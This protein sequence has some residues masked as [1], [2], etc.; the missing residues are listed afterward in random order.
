MR[1]SIIIPVYNVEKYL[2]EC[3]DSILSQTIKDFEIILVDDGST[4]SSGKICD[5]YFVKYSNIKVIH[6]NNGGLSEARNIGLRNA[7]GEY[8][9]FV[10]SDDY[11]IDNNVINKLNEKLLS[12]PDIVIFTHIKWFESSGKMSIPNLNLI[13]SRNA[14]TPAQKYIELIDCDGY[15]NSAWSKVIKRS[16][17]IDNNI[18][19][20]KGLLGEDN[21]W[22][23]KVVSHIQSM[24]IIN[25][26]LYVY[27]QRKGSIT[28]S[29]NNKNLEDLLWIIEKWI[30][31]VNEGVLDEN[32][33]IIR[34]S[35]AKQYCHAIIG[36]CNLKK[37]DGFY[38][39]LKSLNYLLQFSNNP[40]VKTFRLLNKFIGF[41]GIIILLKMR[42]IIKH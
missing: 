22:Y 8:V 39:R 26:A 2:H 21:D 30:R 11:L 10:D 5:E 17:L 33:M 4:D 13:V 1:L 25:E 40:R 24:E 18:E 32:K 35:L 6:K 20:E 38:P 23:Y 9:F 16:L 14:M 34:N 41:K 15:Y 7:N 29:H 36:Y 12:N 3:I 28:K 31:Y 42:N 27:R 19:F 37:P